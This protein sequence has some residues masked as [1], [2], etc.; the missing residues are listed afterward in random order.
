MFALHPLHVESVAWVSERKDVLSGLFCML[1]LWAYAGYVERPR[2]ARLLLVTLCLLL[3]L[4]SKATLVTLPAVLLLLDWW[5]LGRL[6][7][8]A[9]PGPGVRVTLRRAVLEK[10]PMFLLAAAVSTV[11]F[12]VGRAA[13]GMSSLAVVSLGARVRNAL[14]AYVLYAAKSFWP[15]GLAVFYPLRVEGSPVW[16]GLAAAL[17]LVA[18]SPVRSAPCARTALPRASAGSGTWGCSS[19][20][21][22]SSRS[23]CRR[24]PIASCT[25]R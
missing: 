20:R 11:I 23:A 2:M 14:E 6:G 17:L 13:G 21:S 19:P 8:K 3:G 18:V 22:G 4:L 10:I 24:A 16:P 1:A 9:P 5:P 15:S 7:A 12:L 25:C